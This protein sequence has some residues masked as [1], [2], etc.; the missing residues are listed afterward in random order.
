M[1][2]ITKGEDVSVQSPATIKR[3]M[4]YASIGTGADDESGSA[5]ERAFGFFDQ[6]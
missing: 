2:P 1:S 6:I 4:H 5:S 3:S